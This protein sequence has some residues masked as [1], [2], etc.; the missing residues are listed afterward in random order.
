MSVSGSP[1][2]GD[3]SA[4]DLLAELIRLV[5]STGG[6][7]AA[8][9]ETDLD[10]DPEPR[11]PA[12]APA[13]DDFGKMIPVDADAP[14]TFEFGDT[15][16]P[17]TQTPS[18]PRMLKASAIVLAVSALLGAGFGLMAGRPGGPKAPPVVAAARDPATAPQSSAEPVARVGEAVGT[19]HKGAQPASVNV[20]ASKQEPATVE[21]HPTPDDAPK[22]P[23]AAPAQPAI[24]RS[25]GPP[26]PAPGTAQA[27]M[28]NV[29]DRMSSQAALETPDSAPAQASLRSGMAS[30]ATAAPSVPQTDEPAHAAAALQ[31]PAKP[32]NVESAPTAAAPRSPPI[33]ELTVMPPKRPRIL[34][35]KAEAAAP[36]A[37]AQPPGEP[38]HS[39]ATIIAPPAVQPQ[40][41]PPPAPEVLSQPLAPLAHAINTVA[42]VFG[43]SA[44]AQRPV[45]LIAV[46]AQSSDWAVQFDTPKSEAQARSEASRLSAKY[47]G[48]LN[49]AKISVQKTQ[50]N[51]ET[52]YALRASGLSKAEAAVLCD[53]VNGH[54]CSLA[55]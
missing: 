13:A 53:R 55:K 18:R 43:R 11:Q 21:A 12:S 2:A 52:I 35:A 41:P 6:V 44:P 46:S 24:A 38:L 40:A 47:A 8:A 5:E 31:E 32:A 1:Q 34:V 3:R 4:E 51:G 36:G 29:V 33:A 39:G 14:E 27:V 30:G 9:A 26:T 49:G 19:P 16:Q 25:A 54:D 7:A 22:P 10:P 15:R 45:E 37:E 17:Q 28:D 23:A 50:A 48:S 42:G 20:T